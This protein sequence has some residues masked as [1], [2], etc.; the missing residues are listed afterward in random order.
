MK[1]GAALVVMGGLVLAA[2]APASATEATCRLAAAARASSLYGREAKTFGS[3]AQHLASA[4]AC[5]AAKRDAKVASAL[6]QAEAALLAA[7]DATVATALGFTSRDALAVRVA[8]TAA[9]EGR[10]ITDSVYGRDPTPLPPTTAKCAKAIVKRSTTAGKAVVTRLIPCAGSCDP[11]VN[12]L[13]DAAVAKATAAILRSCGAAELSALVG[14]DLAGH[15]ATIRADAERVVNAFHPGA[16]PVVSVAAPAPGTILVP[17]GLPASVALET[18]VANVPHASYVNS[19]TV[20]GFP[21][22]FDPA[23]G[24]FDRTLSLST[25]KATVRVF[26]T[27]RTTLGTVSGVGTLRFNL[28]GLSPGVVITA[29]P[30]GTITPGAAVTVAGQVIGNLTAADIL[31]V[32]GSPVSFDGTTG[33]FS[34]S[35]PIGPQV[36]N[37]IRASVQSLSLGTSDADSVVVLK[38]AALGLG[39]RVPGANTNRMNNSGLAHARSLVKS[40]LDAALAPANFIG[41]G[42][43]GGTIDAFSIGASSA[44]I[45]GGGANT[46]QLRLSLDNF[47]LHVRDI[48]FFNCSATY[49][50]QNILVDAH[51]NLVGQLQASITL[52]QVTFTNDDG[53]VGGICS[54]VGFL[55]DVRTDTRNTL[56]AKVNE[57]L[58]AALDS[59]LAGIDISGP[60]GTAL[61]VLIDASYADIPED[62]QG[63]TFLVDSNMIALQPIPDAPPITATLVP[64]PV[65]PPVLGPTIPSTATPYDLAL[66]LSDGFV[67]RAMAAFMLQ[68]RFNLS[69]SELPTG[70]GTVPLTTLLMSALLGDPSYQHACPGCPVTLALRPTAAAVA[71]PPQPAE[72]ATVVLAIPNYRVDVVAHQGATPIPLL[73][74]NVTFDL[75]VTL[76]VSSGSIVPTVGTITVGDVKVTD[77]PIGANETS[78][79]NQVADLFPLAAEA[80]GG[81]FGEITLPSVSGLTVSGAGA[82]YNVSCAAI[83]LNLN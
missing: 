7:C 79:A 1:H 37:V 70:G 74:A 24:R 23:N 48:G 67:N 32:G 8:G 49:N 77:N 35:V 66:C 50:A 68:G 15:L 17:P 83:Y 65:G 30:S 2:R 46:V 21:T 44:D 43:G 69:L 22:T 57:K 34:I 25:P 33:L 26:V 29:P 71:R 10:Q 4:R 78:F 64:T 38:G 47:H 58:Q 56:T 6:S 9:G 27:A 51:V 11:A 19:V 14:G 75:P 53:S 28:S 5:D 31:L 54:L 63:I 45:F 41:T 39:S 82:G 61:D 73:S 55:A 13:I 40:Q 60:I 76:G 36:V 16:G 3:C 62:N 72:N 20:D 18:L 80:L 81:L 12:G 42:A 52:T 59:A